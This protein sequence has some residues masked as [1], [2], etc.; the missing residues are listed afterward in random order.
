LSPTAGDATFDESFN[1]YGMPLAACTVL[2]HE[3][4]NERAL[5]VLAQVRAS[6]TEP[7]HTRWI[8]P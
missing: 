5:A 8:A 6:A 2:R 3:P 7:K 4:D 1:H